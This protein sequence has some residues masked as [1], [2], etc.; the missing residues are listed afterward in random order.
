MLTA[1]EKMQYISLGTM[2][3]NGLLI[4]LGL[5][6]LLGGRGIMAVVAALALSKVAAAALLYHLAGSRVARP[7]WRLERGM[8]AYL[9]RQV[10]LFLSIAFCNALFWSVTV[11]L[12]TWLEGETS[13][14]YFSAAYKLISYMLLFAVAFSQALFPV[15]ARLASQDRALYSQL[16]RRAVHYL[17]M[18]FI[19]AAFVLSLLA[20]PIILFLY[21][22]AMAPA[23]PVLRWLAWMVVPYGVIPALAYTLVSHHRQGRDLWANF[24]AAVTVVIVN[25]FLIPGFSATGAAAAMVAG[26]VVFAA[27]EY[28]SVYAL[29]YPLRPDRRTLALLASAALLALTLYFSQGVNFILRAAAGCSVYTAALWLLQAIDRSDFRQLCLA[30]MPGCKEGMA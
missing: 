6:L 27:V 10:P 7:V 4:L 14:G 30:V 1:A 21:G 20:E 23:V 12:L 18:L 19:G 13:A 15:A 25:L 16:L 26:S 11:V 24:L 8:T 28:G 2:A 29:L 9:L 3:E 22:E 5:S 17:L